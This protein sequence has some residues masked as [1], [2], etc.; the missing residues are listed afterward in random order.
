MLNVAHS[1]IQCLPVQKS[2]IRACNFN[3]FVHHSFTLAYYDIMTLQ[4]SKQNVPAY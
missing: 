2:D 4:A 3:K 1:D